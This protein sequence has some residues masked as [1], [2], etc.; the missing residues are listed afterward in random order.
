[1]ALVR[2]KFWQGQKLGVFQ[3]SGWNP[4]GF[5]VQFTLSVL[6]NERPTASVGAS[7]AVATSSS[8]EEGRLID[9]ET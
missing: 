1:M 8:A 2:T 7:K 9:T 5:T 6:P 4:S 3:G